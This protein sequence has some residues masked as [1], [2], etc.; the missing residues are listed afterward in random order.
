[1]KS[2]FISGILAI[3]GSFL[4]ISCSK[5]DV[6]ENIVKGKMNGVDFSFSTSARAN[7]PEPGSS[8]PDD[9]VLRITGNF[10]AFSFKLI[11]IQQS[12]SINTGTYVFQIDKNYSATITEN[13]IN[14][15]NYYAGPAGFGAPPHLYGSGT[16]TIQEISKKH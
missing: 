12:S 4:L 13:N 8:G 16:V 7:K 3:A 10:D 15:D 2:I 9:P 6:S 1:M 5:N 11:L 14:S